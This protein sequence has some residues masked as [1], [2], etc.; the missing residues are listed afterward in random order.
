MNP[1]LQV[2]GATI[3]YKTPKTLHT[4]TYR[5]SFDAFQGDR[6]ILLGPSGC[7]KSTILKAVGGYLPAVEG[8][9]LLNGQKVTQPGIDR[10]M[11]FQ[12]SDQLAPWLTVL[13]NVMFPLIHGKRMDRAKAREKALFYLDK[14]KL[15]PHLDKHPHELSGGMKARVAIARGMAMEPAILLMDEPFAALDALTRRSMQDELLALLADTKGT[16]LFITHDLSEAVRLGSRILVLSANPGQVLF[17]CD[18]AE[19]ETEALELEKKLH[20][21]LQH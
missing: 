10:M 2:K 19:S 13:G 9:I 16:L 15:T 20:A 17:E 4:A 14:V 12:E 3:Q 11:V 7:G 6:F 8:E 18:G 5:V 21:L 1:L